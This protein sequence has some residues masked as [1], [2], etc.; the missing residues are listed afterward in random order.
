MRIFSAAAVLAGIQASL[1]WGGTMG[2]PIEASI[3]PEDFRKLPSQL[4]DWTG[5]QVSM[6]PRLFGADNAHAVVHRIYKNGTGQGVLLYSAEFANVPV[7]NAPHPP[8]V[9]YPANGF[10]ITSSHDMQIPSSSRGSFLARA[11]T[12]EHEMETRHILFWFQVPGATYVDGYG[13]REVFWSY[14]GRKTHPAVVKVTLETPQ[15]GEQATRSLKSFAPLVH[16]WV[17]Q[18]Q[19]GKRGEGK[20]G[21]R[22]AAQ[23]FRT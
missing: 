4:G 23:D 7:S 15:N 12:V 8:D 13:Q 14:R 2:I 21:R 19:A 3:P 18:Y 20:G 17:T 6:D 10:R 5:E 22:K 11:L 9:C 1:Y 16:A